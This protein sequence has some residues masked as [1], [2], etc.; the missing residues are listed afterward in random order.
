MANKRQ[1]TKDLLNSSPA[2]DAQFG[3]P[4]AAE[5]AQAEEAPP[6]KREKDRITLRLYT[7]TLALLDALKIDARKHG[8]PA[9]YG[10]VVEEA[11]L[12]LARKYDLRI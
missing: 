12:D 4:S 6:A 8:R 10:D 2:L 1:K 9:T 5:V 7:D 3:G 11:I